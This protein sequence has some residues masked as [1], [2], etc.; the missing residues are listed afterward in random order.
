[1]NPHCHL[2]VSGSG[3]GGSCAP[4]PWTPPSIF[5]LI[6]SDPLSSQWGPSHL[7]D[8]AYC[9][10][11]LHEAAR[12]EAPPSGSVYD[13]ERDGAC[14][15]SLGVHEHWND[16]IHKQYSRNLG[17]GDGIELV[18]VPAAPGKR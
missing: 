5:I 14:L 12:A 18:Y 10:S 11:Y 2:T 6:S 16:A 9:D 17:T 8:L 13:P 7:V 15:K 3:R 4:S 1:L